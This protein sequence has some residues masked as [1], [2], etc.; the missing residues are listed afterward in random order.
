[1]YLY[2]GKG[3]KEGADYRIITFVGIPG[4]VHGRGIIERVRAST[5][6]QIGNKQDYFRRRKGC[7][8]VFSC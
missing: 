6:N 7:I 8:G 3:E 2:K 5:E 1:M 4:K